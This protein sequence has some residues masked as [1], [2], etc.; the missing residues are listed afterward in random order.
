MSSDRRY[1]TL[2]HRHTGEINV[3]NGSYTLVSSDD[4]RTISKESGGAGETITI[5]ANS[6]VPFK[7]GT[8]IAISNDGGDDLTI[9]IT[10]DTLEG[11][12]GTTG[13]RTLTDHNVAVVQK[14]T[15][16]KWRYSAT[17]GAASSTTPEHASFFLNT[18]GFTS[19]AAGPQVCTLDQTQINS[20]GAIFSLASNAVTVNKTA[21]FLIVADVGLNQ[22][23]VDNLRSSY[24]MYIEED[25]GGGY[26]E[27]NGCSAEMYVR[28]YD[29]GTSGT[30]TT[31]L[32]VTTGD[33]FRLSVVR[34]DG[35]STNTYQDS[36]GTRLSFLEVA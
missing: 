29:S 9:A 15:A 30:I 20:D 25:S 1:S 22:A 27:V 2:G 24:R 36:D 10:T 34:A 19:L 3:Q 14:V 11:T 5:P 35:A 6:A 8:T 17:D 31:I 13:S 28:G 33:K 23:D 26:A 32:S 16:T 18:G 21:V 12:D 7:I 4:G